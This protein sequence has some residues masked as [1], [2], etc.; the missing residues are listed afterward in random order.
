MRNRLLLL[1]VLA[2]LAA[3]LLVPA[4]APA[5]SKAADTVFLNGTVYTVDRCGTVATA[6]AV[7]DG[8]II[9]VGSE[10]HM[11][12]YISKKTTQVIDLKGKMVLPGF[13]DA[14]AHINMTVAFL[15]S[16]NLYGLPDLAAYQQAIADFDGQYPG[17]DVIRGQGFSEAMFPGI[18]PLKEDID[19]VV[20]DRPVVIRSDGYHS[21][22][23]NS[24]ALAQ[25]GIDGTTPNPE[26]GVIER[27][28]GTV[29]AP[30]TPYGEPSGTLRE[31]AAGL[32]DAIVGDYS[33][34][35]YKDG[36][37][38][39]QDAWA[40]PLGY[41]LIHDPLLTPGSNALQAYEEL[42]QAGELTMRVRGAL[43]LGPG[44]VGGSGGTIEEQLAAAVE[45]RAKHT[46][47]LFK[48]PAVK[49]FQDGVIEGHTGFLLED[50]ADTP[51]YRG[52]PIWPQDELEAACDMSD[53]LGFQL[54]THGI[55]DA[56]VRSLLDAFEYTQD[57]NGVADRRPLVTH[58]QLAAPEDILRFGELG[59]V[60]EPQPYW[61]VKDDY[62]YNVQVPFL[63]QERADLEYPMK[64]FFDAGAVVAS[65]SDF[66]VTP[67]PD[68]LD[69][70]QVAVMRWTDDPIFGGN[71]DPTE[72][73]WPEERVTLDQAIRSFTTGPARA[74]FLEGA[75]GTLKVGKSA[76]LVVVDR[77]LT[78]IAPEELN[79]A[80]V[81]LTMFRGETV[82]DI[83]MD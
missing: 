21:V 70:I 10:K 42:A 31:T 36:L 53:D 59:V 80:V 1:L 67:W 22:W 46:S 7:R 37:R 45:E 9:A 83:M 79:D 51:G 47:A 62:Y 58:L 44:A 32:V 43:S 39:F 3:L 77:D 24:F 16:V 2:A 5:K 13:G 64:S 63:G 56:A 76:D 73:L 30:G 4:S 19:A 71:P 33:V 66:P 72:I 28:P 35:Q 57:E 29:G 68:P 12:R 38:Y 17:S 49:I 23:V 27:V 40:K 78:T 74:N 65:S 48:T 18:G 69:G 15:Y 55:G 25:A 26:D 61:M 60:A 82:Y 75:T 50:Y 14:H 11:K 20:D 54:H 8:K 34:D 81:L 41:T 6:I 52:E